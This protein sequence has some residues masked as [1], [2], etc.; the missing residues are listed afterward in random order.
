MDW[1]LNTTFYMAVESICKYLIK[2]FYILKVLTYCGKYD[3]LVIAFHRSFFYAQI[4]YQIN[5]LSIA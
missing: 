1:L 3:I 4:K 2:R 5:V